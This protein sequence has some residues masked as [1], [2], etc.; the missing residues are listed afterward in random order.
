MTLAYNEPKYQIESS[1]FHCSSCEK[2]IPREGRFYSAVVLVDEAFQRRNYC[3]P[4]WKPDPAQVFAYWKS[5]RP[6]AG[7]EG[8]TKVRFDTTLVF[9][10]FRK[11]GEASNGE[12]PAEG[13]RVE[14]RFVLAL[15]LV[16]KKVLIFENSYQVDGA[17]CLKLIERG[18]PGAAEPRPVHWVKNPQ[19]ADSELERVKDR[20]GEL[21]LMQV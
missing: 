3:E 21:L 18:E 8:P 20:I 11:L 4:C 14:V 12:G 7:K 13:E 1:N 9:E 2:E 10:F 16:R 17:E 5:R 15:L 19:L 6:P